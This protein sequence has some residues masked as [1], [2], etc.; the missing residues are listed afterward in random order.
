MTVKSNKPVVAS[1]ERDLKQL[2]IGTF[3]RTVMKPARRFL[4]YFGMCQCQINV[5][6]YRGEIAWLVVL[7]RLRGL[8]FSKQLCL[9]NSCG[10]TTLDCLP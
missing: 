1:P 2:S 5:S 9:V 8:I 7:K 10:E 6:G 4:V 3:H